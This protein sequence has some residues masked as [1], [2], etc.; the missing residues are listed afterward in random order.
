MPQESLRNGPRIRRHSLGIFASRLWVKKWPRSRI[1]LE[2]ALPLSSVR[3]D[4]SLAF[5]AVSDGKSPNE[6]K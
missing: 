3:I 6:N 5:Q 4:L 1:L 2:D